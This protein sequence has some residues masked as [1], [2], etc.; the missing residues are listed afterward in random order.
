MDYTY[1]IKDFVPNTQS[2][3]NIEAIEKNIK[4]VI[5][6][7]KEHNKLCRL[8]KDKLNTIDAKKVILDLA[9]IDNTLNIS[10]VT[11][12]NTTSNINLLDPELK[13]LNIY[14]C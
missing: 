4:K 8:K 2:T 13:A 11:Y 3:L 12:T 1:A 9:F 14:K 5:N 7:I 6:A 10:L